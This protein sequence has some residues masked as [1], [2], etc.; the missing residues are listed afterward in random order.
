MTYIFVL[1]LLSLSIVYWFESLGFLFR[2]AGFKCNNPV[3]GYSL[4]NSLGFASRFFVL[5]FSPVFAF[6]ADTKNIDLSIAILVIFYLCII[7][8]LYINL[9]LEKEIVNILSRVVK[10]VMNGSNLLSAIYHEKILIDIFKLPILIFK[11]KGKIVNSNSKIDLSVL[12]SIERRFAKRHLSIYSYTY[13]PFYSCWSLISVMIMQVPSKPAF[14]ISMST[15]LTLS[16]TIYQ[17]VYFDPWISQYSNNPELS[18]NIYTLLQRK[19]L[20]SSFYSFI[21]CLGILIIFNY[22]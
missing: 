21:I 4:Q 14:F 12:T 9:S 5:L 16:N 1:S 6:L 8:L 20:I 2:S 13:I 17:S 7:S 10:Q 15:F 11:K 19:K 18:C 3:T 22:F